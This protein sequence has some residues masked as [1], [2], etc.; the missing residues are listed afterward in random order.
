MQT[1]GSFNRQFNIT[2]KEAQAIEQAWEIEQG[3]TMFHV[4]N[5]YTRAA[6]DPSLSAEEVYKLERAGGL[7]LSMVKN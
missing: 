1:I 7:I 3:F 2:R 4:I 6:Q 5:A